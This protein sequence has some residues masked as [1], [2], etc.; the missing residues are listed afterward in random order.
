[1]KWIVGI[2]LLLSVAVSDEAS[3]ES[4]SITTI[5]LAP[6]SEFYNTKETTIRY[7][8]FHFADKKIEKKI[9][10]TIRV[11][12]LEE[13]AMADEAPSKYSDKGLLK[14]CI[15]S[16]LTSLSVDTVTYVSDNL[17][18]FQIGYEWVGAYPTS[19]KRYFTFDLTTGKQLTIDDLIKAD[20]RAVF[21]KLLRTLQHKVIE[22][23]RAASLENAKTKQISQDDL[24]IIEDHIKSD[25]MQ[26]FDSTRF[27]IYPYA[28]VVMIDC[29]FPH[30]IQ[31]LDD[32]DNVVV[33]KK[34][35]LPFIDDRFKY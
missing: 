18:S 21:R 23:F 27:S 13:L 8:I 17:I 16:G 22:K 2:V 12:F 15:V 32:H 9:N 4:Y 34:V 5:D 7:P 10:K 20:K 30:A 19:G 3:A 28:M 11:E 35:L 1:M 25:C 26:S 29:E 6:K 24:D 14:L 31:A 33:S